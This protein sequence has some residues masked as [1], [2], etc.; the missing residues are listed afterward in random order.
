MHPIGEKQEF[1]FVVEIR[2]NWEQSAVKSHEPGVVS[3]SL[4][5]V[6]LI[7]LVSFV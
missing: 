6:I 4:S 1:C 7:E 3:C 5:K 2:I